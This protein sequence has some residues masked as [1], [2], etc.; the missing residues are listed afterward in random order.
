MPQQQNRPVFLNLFQI[1]LPPTAIVSILHRVAGVLLILFLPFLIYLFDMSLQ[2]KLTF[3]QAA[4]LVDYPLV[5]AIL[6]I[7]LWAI[8]HHFVAGIRY[9]LI[10]FEMISSR[11]AARTSAVIVFIVGLLVPVFAW[12]G[13]QL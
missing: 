6:Y 7:L 4:E 1:K 10:D 9:F 3:T 12:F 11:S 2:D 8:S 5:S 13:N